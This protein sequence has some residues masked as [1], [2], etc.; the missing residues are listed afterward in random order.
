MK[1]S[2]FLKT[3]FFLACIGLAAVSCSGSKQ[4]AL[5]FYQ[6]GTDS[7]GQSG[8]GTLYLWEPGDTAAKSIAAISAGDRVVAPAPTPGQVIIAK[9]DAEEYY[10]LDVS[11][12]QTGD[13]LSCSWNPQL[14]YHGNEY[15]GQVN[16]VL[17]SSGYILYPSSEGW[18]L[19]PWE[20]GEPK[21]TV[22]L[23]NRPA[24][25]SADGA[26]ILFINRSNPA[27]GI[28]L[29]HVSTGQSEA[30]KL[31]QPGEVEYFAFSP[32][33]DSIAFV[34]YFQKN[35]DYYVARPDGSDAALV[36]PC[37]ISP[38]SED[39]NTENSQCSYDWSPDGLE[40]AVVGEHTS[41]LSEIFI[42]RKDG[43][44]LRDVTKAPGLNT[45]PRWSPSGKYLS[46]LS[47]RDFIGH[48]YISFGV[49]VLNPATGEQISL[50]A[51]DSYLG[52]WLER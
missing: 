3:G 28:F 1:N 14:V 32:Q 42:V 47:G 4:D 7:G 35:A 33:G 34:R 48:Y 17:F 43:T 20:D 29:Y 23:D 30:F 50:G 12:G 36:A 6:P 24:A 15:P 26:S 44:G 52:A 39:V 5:V 13:C 11:S 40:L 49:W 45:G 38:A 31:D 25:L 10:F 41:S 51:E 18:I 9:T 37:T 19:L 27:Q 16:R 22:S 8:S 2:S 21:V 46:F